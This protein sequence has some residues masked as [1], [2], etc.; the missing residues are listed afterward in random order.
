M[1]RHAADRP[2][3]PPLHAD[4]F[5]PTPGSAAARAAHQRAAAVFDNLVAP[6]REALG[7]Y[8]LRLTGGDEAAA[9]SLLK[10]TLYR[11][12][13]DPARYPQRASAV[14]P[15]LVLTARTI[16]RDAA[17]TAGHDDRPPAPDQPPPPSAATTIVRA[18]DDLAAAHRDLLVELFYQGVSLEDAA[19]E[20]GLPVET[21]KS[22][23]YF[24]MRSLRVVLDQQLA[25]RPGPRGGHRR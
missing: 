6:H 9:E 21:L 15:W 19:A 12:A 3:Q 2:R 17:R 4:L 8:V 13:Q 7:T 1:G 5:V 16:Q 11:A 20:R 22:R 14:R 24:A 18:M 25:D 23:L 10:E